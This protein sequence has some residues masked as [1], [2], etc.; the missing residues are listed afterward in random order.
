MVC[1]FSTLN[2]GAAGGRVARM[3]ASGC[4]TEAGGCAA[5]WVIASVAL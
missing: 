1:S 2:H 3:R 5:Q 4:L